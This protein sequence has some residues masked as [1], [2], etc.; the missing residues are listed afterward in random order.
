MVNFIR[1]TPFLRDFSRIWFL[2]F[3]LHL[4]EVLEKMHWKY[5]SMHMNKVHNE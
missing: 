1:F 3:A 2:I 4:N 5:S